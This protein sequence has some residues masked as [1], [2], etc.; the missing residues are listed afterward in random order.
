MRG[1]P[2]L[3]MKD[4]ELSQAF[5]GE[6]ARRCHVQ[7]RKRSRANECASWTA[8]LAPVAFPAGKKAEEIVPHS[9]GVLLH[10]DPQVTDIRDGQSR[11]GKTV[12]GAQADMDHAILDFH[13]G[14]I[15][16]SEVFVGPRGHHKF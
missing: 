8:A 15:F 5:L 16:L 6:T 11:V 2:T 10:G 13:S 12:V 14:E 3:S 9:T 1:T 7:S 4:R